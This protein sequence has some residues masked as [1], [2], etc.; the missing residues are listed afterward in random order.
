MPLYVRYLSRKIIN[1]P[2]LEDIAEKTLNMMHKKNA[3]IGLVF[4]GKKRMKDLNKMYRGKDKV[5]DVLSFGNNGGKKD[6]FISPRET[7][8]NLGEIFICM[9]RVKEQA[10]E[11][12]HS[13]KKE[14]GT[15]LIHGILHLMG[16][17]H[18]RD[19]DARIMRRKENKLI[20]EL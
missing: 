14:A 8:E 3:E 16:F 4:V 19:E 2:Y 7:V 10:K 13:A 18:K 17:D 9:E 1:K 11:K 5:T 12:G 15:L 20:A 6:K